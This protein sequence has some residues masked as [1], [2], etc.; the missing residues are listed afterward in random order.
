MSTKVKAGLV[1]PGPFFWL[2]CRQPTLPHR[3]LL[4]S[5]NVGQSHS[6]DGHRYADNSVASGH[7]FLRFAVRFR[8]VF[9]AFRFLAM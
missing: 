3:L 9:F 7:R 8:F 4:H 6:Q 1:T 2:H 5:A